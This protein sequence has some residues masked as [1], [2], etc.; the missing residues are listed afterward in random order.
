MAPLSGLCHGPQPDFLGLTVKVRDQDPEL[1][2][3]ELGV[4][5]DRFPDRQ[6]AGPEVLGASWLPLGDNPGHSLL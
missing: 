6:S 1:P 3:P 5:S 4:S 2:A